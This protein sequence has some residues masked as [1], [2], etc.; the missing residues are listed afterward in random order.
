LLLDGLTDCEDPEC[1]ESPVCQKS[2]L[3]HTVPQPID[4][5]LR[6]QPPAMTASF[7]EQ[8]KFIIEDKGLQSYVQ[9]A[10]FNERYKITLTS[11]C[12]FRQMW[13]RGVGGREAELR[14]VRCN[15]IELVPAVGRGG[16]TGHLVKTGAVHADLIIGTTAAQFRGP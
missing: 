3:C 14:N 10:G 15:S 12:F 2:Q 11:G 13:V 4:I 5:L 7:F 6:K 8:M 1:C 16:G 9:R